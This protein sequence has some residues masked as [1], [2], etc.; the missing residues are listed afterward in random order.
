M[1]IIE[2]V[3]Q[4]EKMVE[5]AH[6]Y[7]VNHSTIGTK[8]QGQDH[9]TCEVFCAGY[10]SNNTEESWKMMEEMKK[11]LSV[12]RQDQHH[13]WVL[14]NL[15]LIQEKA[16]SLFEDLKKHGKESEGASFNASHGPGGTSG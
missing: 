5:V 1:K 9:G 8:E 14:L 7:N 16:K 15:M 6:S 11:L 10:V 3:E 12:W 2:R 13:H 4:D